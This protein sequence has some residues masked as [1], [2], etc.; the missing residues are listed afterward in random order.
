MQHSM[1][2]MHHYNHYCCMW[3][4]GDDSMSYFKLN[5][6]VW[7]F[8]ADSSR[9]NIYPDWINLRTGKVIWLSQIEEI[10]HVY[11][12]GEPYIHVLLNDDTHVFRC[13]ESALHAINKRIAELR[14]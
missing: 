2:S 1:H 8:S 4:R 12:D 9:D 3:L 10:M 7:W 11:I 5:D 6:E 13:K 14:E